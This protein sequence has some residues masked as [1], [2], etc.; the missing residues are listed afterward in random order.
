[1]HILR[2][3]GT[4]GLTGMRT[5]KRTAFH[6]SIPL[7][8]P[9]LDVWRD[10]IE[11]YCQQHG[12][13]IRVD[14]SNQDQNYL[15]NRIRHS[16]LPDLQSY[17][18]SVKQNLL[19]L[20]EIVRDDW[21]YLINQYEVLYR[22][23][24]KEE[25]EGI[26]SFSSSTLENLP[27]GAQK[28]LIQIALQALVPGEKQIDHEMVLSVVRFNNHPKPTKHIS[29]PNGLHAFVKEGKL[30]LSQYDTLPLSHPY[31]QCEHA[32]SIKVNEDNTYPLGNG[33]ELQVNLLVRDIYETPIETDGLLWEA[34]LD[35]DI[36]GTGS[37]DVRAFQPGDRYQ[38][39]GM[40]GKSIKLSDLFINKKIPAQLRSHWMLV[41]NHTD[42]LWVAGFPP[43]HNARINPDTQRLLH[44]QIIR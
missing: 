9:L 31:P 42:I 2:G 43:A 41:E 21:D 10:Q 23:L 18:P 25:G 5:S 16:L 34:Y 28:A 1:M 8:R 3:S 29:L 37:L 30:I 15:R 22:D 36:L 11:Q 39:L 26:L 13:E 44:L 32:F 17:N 19:N 7:V 4:Q 35:A 20:A 40:G 24:I 38:P 14:E 33:M 27:L 6:P 12:L